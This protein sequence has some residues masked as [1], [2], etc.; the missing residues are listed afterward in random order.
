MHFYFIGVPSAKCAIGFGSA[1]FN[2]IAVRAFINFTL[3]PQNN[4]LKISVEHLLGL[5]SFFFSFH[6]F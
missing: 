4:H 6:R 1:Y 3:R 2:I 5:F